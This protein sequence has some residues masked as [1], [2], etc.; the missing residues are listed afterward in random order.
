MLLANRSNDY[1]FYFNRCVAGVLKSPRWTSD[2]ALK[3]DNESVSEPAKTESIYFWTLKAIRFD[4]LLHLCW[5][6]CDQMKLNFAVGRFSSI[7]RNFLISLF[8]PFQPKKCLNF[9]H[10]VNFSKALITELTGGKFASFGL[11]LVKQYLVVLMLLPIFD[12][13]QSTSSG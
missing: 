11:S 7:G 6:Q 3:P 12:Y 8:L 2:R 5:A 1:F 4:C 10:T 9:G 13:F